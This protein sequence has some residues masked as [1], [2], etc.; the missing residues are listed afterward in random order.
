MKQ[1]L[2]VLLGIAILCGVAFLIYSFVPEYPHNFMKSFI[3]P[4]IDTEA[5]LRIQ[6]VKNIP[7][8]D[9]EGVNYEQALAKNSGMNCWVYEKE[10]AEGADKKVDKPISTKVVFRGNGASIN[11]KDFTEYGGKLYTSAY[12]KIEFIINGTD[13][14]II[15]YID[16][17][18][19]Y[20][21][22]KK[23]KDANKAIR[24]SIIQQMY[25]GLQEE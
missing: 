21:D 18:K 16:N 17:Q 8:P 6:Q 23:H 10:Y 20:I 15:P 13:V 25:G 11:I 7:A 3:Q 2:K 5:K 4:V 14:T 24:D 12:V 19:M 1:F 22:D 9:I